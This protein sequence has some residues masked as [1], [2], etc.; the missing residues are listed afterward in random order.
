MVALRIYAVE[1]IKSEVKSHLNNKRLKTKTD[2]SL[3]T[4]FGRLF[5]QFIRLQAKEWALQLTLHCGF[6][7]LKSPRVL[8]SNRTS[9]KA[10]TA[11]K[12][13]NILYITPISILWYRV[14]FICLMPS[15]HYQ[16]NT[17]LRN[18]ILRLSSAWILVASKQLKRLE[19]SY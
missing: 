3:R 12:P 16:V 15:M 13:W 11:T 8:S 2:D 14:Q 5:Q 19:V 9:N 4:S 10:S 7:I 18:R 17:Q 1:H 6:K